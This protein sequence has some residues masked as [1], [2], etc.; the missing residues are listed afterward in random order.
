[1]NI[2]AAR[3]NAGRAGTGGAAAKAP[4]RRRRGTSSR[5]VAEVLDELTAWNPREFI[6]AFQRWHQG[7]ISLIQLNVLAFLEASGPLPLNRLAEALDI[8]VASLTG[9]ID[10][11]E[12]RD[13]VERRRDVED[14]RVILVEP[15]EG[16]RRV[17]AEID[18]RRRTGLATLLGSL[19][20]AE[21]HGLLE[22]HRAL[23][24]ARVEMARRLT[25]D[26]VD[27]LVARAKDARAKA[28]RAKAERRAKVDQVVARARAARVGRIEEIV[29]RAKGG[30]R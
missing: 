21:L 19:S 26:K 11:M 5:L 24:A 22:G 23:R 1:L 10:R 16:G 6:A 27:A 4:A 13:L 2:Q 28:A 25:P 3:S 15:G 20:D 7:Q 9:V 12:A 29:A 14:R 18:Q 17:F 8:S 30:D